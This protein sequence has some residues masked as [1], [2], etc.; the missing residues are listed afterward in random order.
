MPDHADFLYLAFDPLASPQ[1]IKHLHQ[2]LNPLNEREKQHLMINLQV[3]PDSTATDW[4]HYQQIYQQL[5]RQGIQKIGIDHYQ[6]ANG[7]TVHQHLYREL[8][9]NARPLSYHAPYVLEQ[10]EH[11]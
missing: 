2:A 9:L 3:N 11:K 1:A 10:G 7:Q 8:S 6:L 4:R 5:K